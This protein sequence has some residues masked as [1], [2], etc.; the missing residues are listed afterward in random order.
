MEGHEFEVVRV[1]TDAEMGGAGEGL[2]EGGVVGD[3]N[4]R[5]GDM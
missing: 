1:G 5:R 4:F 3:E 2:G